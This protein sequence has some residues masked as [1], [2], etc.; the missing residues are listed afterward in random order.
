MDQ[1]DFLEAAQAVISTELLTTLEWLA[2]H[3]ETLVKELLKKA[4]K[5]GLQE[6]IIELQE[7]NNAT[8]PIELIGYVTLFF[9]QLEITL[10]ELL[11]EETEKSPQVHTPKSVKQAIE[12]IDENSYDSKVITESIS[13]TNRALKKDQTLNAKKTFFKEFLK[14]WN[15]QKKNSIQ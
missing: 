13:K 15:P 14:N 12:T 2:L 7:E 4:L 11:Q 5:H 9:E 10:S 8:K 3:E 6:K 1:N